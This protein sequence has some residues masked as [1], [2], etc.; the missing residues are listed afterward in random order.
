MNTSI[1]LYGIASVL[2]LFSFLKDRK[3]TKQAL[4]KSWMSFNKLMPTLIP[5][6]IFVGLSLAVVN[7]TLINQLIGNDS[8]MLGI[9]IAIALGSVI[10]M[11]SFVAFPLGALLLQQGAGYPQIAG[12]V[13]ALM[14]V[15]FTSL[16]VEYKYFGKKA[17]LMRNVL[18]IF[19]AILF[20]ILAWSVM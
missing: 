2:L 9:L 13:G 20:S 11:P 3:K 4:K 8:G 18:G 1:L 10:F 15:G 12:F 5:M 16:P 7:P 6:M 14:G 17:T 19:S